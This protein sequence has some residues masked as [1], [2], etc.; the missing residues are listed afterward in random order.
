VKVAP[1]LGGLILV[2]VLVEYAAPGRDLYHYGW[3]NVLVA[4]VAV[5]MLAVTPAAVKALSA[6]ARAGV[7]LFSLGIAAVAFAGVTS[8]LL[9]P[10]NQTIVG[11][12]GSSV[13]VAQAGGTLVFPL[14]QDA[15]D[16]SV[17]LEHGSG[18]SPVGRERFTMNALLRAADRTVVAIDARDARGA[19]LT[20]TQPTGAAFLSPVLLMQ[21]Q[22]TI[23]GLSLPYDSFAL[24]GVHRIVKTVLFSAAQAGALPALAGANG[25]V[26]LFDLEDETGTSIPHGISIAPSGRTVTIAAIRLTP[27][28]LSYPA[29]GVIAVPNV[30]VVAA[31]I[32]AAAIGLVLTLRRNQG[33]M[34]QR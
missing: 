20:I 11:A 18:A 21:Q 23:G 7:W 12:P 34:P 25:P 1:V 27:R 26:V 28:V 5:W 6:R 30:A 8:G 2:L 33:T 9:A 14:A 17:M 19:H 15:D 3:Y 24:P 10:D 13:P 4:A 22:Q 31:G 16:A 32:L 29:I